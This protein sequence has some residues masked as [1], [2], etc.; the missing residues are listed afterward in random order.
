MRQTGTRAAP[1][2][3]APEYALWTHVGTESVYFYPPGSVEEHM[4]TE[5]GIPSVDMHWRV[6]GYYDHAGDHL[7]QPGARTGMVGDL[8]AAAHEHEP[9]EQGEAAA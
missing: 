5:H 8:L 1:M 4:V 6:K 9:P 3:E 2:I 7:R